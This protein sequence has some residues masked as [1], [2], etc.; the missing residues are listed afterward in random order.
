M[1]EI[2]ILILI[3][4]FLIVFFR[5]KYYDLY[6]NE[7]YITVKAKSGLSNKIRVILSYLYRA[8]KEDKKLKVIWIVDDECPEEYSNLFEPIENMTVI[9]TNTNYDYATWEPDNIE[10]INNNYLKLLKPLPQIQTIID[11]NKNELGNKYI[12]CHVRRTDALSHFVHKI[13][14]NKEYMNFID[15]YDNH[16]PKMKI[17]LATDN[18]E[19]Q[20]KFLDKYGNRLLLKKIIPSDKLRQTSVQD[21]VIDIYTCAG[22]EYFMG[23]VGSSFTDLI[24]QLRKNK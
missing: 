17:Y 10:Y 8:N 24:N 7:P 3:L 20:D 6:V 12:S 15:S 11:S 23:S 16:N 2:Y 1:K 13:K 19:T 22:A 18:K 4:V 14:F 21:A 5:N 9:S